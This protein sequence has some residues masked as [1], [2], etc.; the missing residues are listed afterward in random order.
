[1]KWDEIFVGVFFLAHVGYGPQD[2]SL[3]RYPPP[4]E[5]NTQVLPQKTP[6]IGRKSDPVPSMNLVADFLRQDI[7]WSFSPRFA[8][9]FIFYYFEAT[10]QRFSPPQ[11]KWVPGDFGPLTYLEI[12]YQ[13]TSCNVFVFDFFVIFSIELHSVSKYLKGLC[14]APHEKCGNGPRISPLSSLNRFAYINI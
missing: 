12:F 8:M 13:K 11:S 5:T 7:D 9:G 10:C 6:K 3:A 4:K 1:M 2:R 14:L